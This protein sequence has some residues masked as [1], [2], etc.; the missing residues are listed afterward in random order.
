M[1]HHN[2]STCK[3]RLGI[4][5]RRANLALVARALIFIT[6]DLLVLALTLLH[7]R[8]KLGIIVLSNSTRCHLDLAVTAR[9]CDARLDVFNGLLESGDT[10]VLVK[11]LRGKDYNY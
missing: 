10:G 2:R 1:S 7:E 8:S 5:S 9:F 11:T 4:S 6:A 3:S